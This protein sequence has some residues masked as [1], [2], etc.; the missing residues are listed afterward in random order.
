M[1]W[2]K[3]FFDSMS[4]TR[5]D[6]DPTAVRTR[7]KGGANA[8]KH[9]TDRAGEA[10]SKLLPGDRTSK[11]QYQHSSTQKEKKEVVKKDA[12]ASVD[13]PE[14]QQKKKVAS[15]TTKKPLKESSDANKPKATA[16]PIKRTQSAQAP[17]AAAPDA[18]SVK[19]LGSLK[20]EHASLQMTVEGEQAHSR[21]STLA[22]KHTH[23]WSRMCEWHPLRSATYPTARNALLRT[24]GEERAVRNALLE[25]TGE[26]GQLK[27]RC[28]GRAARNNR[29]RTN[30]RLRT[31]GSE[32]PAQNH[33]LGS[34]C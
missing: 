30:Y 10:G 23:A 13:K 17:R 3:A 26:N 28:S 27:T 9:M 16:N 6:Y 34:R 1:Q 21:A 11:S 7:G 15:T 20:K 24:T 22:S 32:P 31:T 33:R 12:G 5:E 19:E 8:K 14:Q 29:L 18:T 2:F 4:I 25:T